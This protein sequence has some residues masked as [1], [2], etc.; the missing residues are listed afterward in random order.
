MMN[1]AAEELTRAQKHWFWAWAWCNGDGN[2]QG[3]A[4]STDLRHW[5][6]A[7][8]AGLVHI[9]GRG[10]H[11]VRKGVVPCQEA[12]PI[13]QEPSRPQNAEIYEHTN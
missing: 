7:R 2:T 11:R 9:N 10:N 8:A 4:G 1:R 5:R 3:T 12:G 6:V 13:Y